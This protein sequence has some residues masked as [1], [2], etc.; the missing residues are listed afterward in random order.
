MSRSTKPIP[1]FRPSIGR[2]EFNAVKRVLKSGWLTTG[3]ETMAFEKEFAAVL[4]NGGTEGRQPVQTLCVNSA[5]SGL[6]LALEAIG[7]GPGDLVAVPTMTFTATAEIV[8]YLGA[9]PLFI[10]SEPG[11][12]NMSVQSLKTACNRA[13][14]SGKTVKAVIAVHI[15][16][17]PCD[18]RE[19]RLAVE[20]TGAAIVEDSAH[21]FP[22]DTPEGM[23]GTLGDIG[24]FSF[25]VTKTIT[26]GEGGLVA[27]RNP[28]YLKRMR[29][30]RLHGIDRDV[31]NRYSEDAGARAWEYDVR[32]AGFKYNMTDLAAAIGRVQLTRARGLLLERKNLAARYTQNLSGL[33]DL[34]LPGDTAGHAWHLYIIKLKDS[35]MRDFLA[36]KL[37]KE[38]IGTSVH[39]IPLHRMSYWKDQ[40]KL[41]TANYPVAEN[42]SQRILSLPLW[43]GLSVKDQRRIIKTIR[44]AL[45]G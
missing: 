1:F 45:H 5:T 18:I 12:G 4:E 7:V 3:P 33:R 8:R 42:L 29:L 16:G 23:A 14:K 41:E 2:S 19:I 6:H 43:P 20:G 34:E 9:D 30:M 24:V 44:G 40:Y 17:F 32:A 21:A 11:S 35:D 10:D 26:T 39:F 37:E 28:E 36:D 31:W 38:G 22:S 13:V 25:Y 15:A 27:T